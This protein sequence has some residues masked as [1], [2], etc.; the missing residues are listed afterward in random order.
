MTTSPSPGA[1]AR[2]CSM[3]SSTRARCR[4]IR[5]DANAPQ[6]GSLVQRRERA[7]EL[8][9]R[10]VRVRHDPFVRGRALAVHLRDDERHA[11]REPERGRL[12][13]A[14]CAALDGRRHQL[15]CSVP[16]RRRRSRGRA[17][18]RRA[19]RPSLPRPRARRPRRRRS[20]RRSGR[21][22]RA[23][24]AEATLG[25][26]RQRDLPDCAGRADDADAGISHASSSPR[27][28]RARRRHAALR[29]A[30][31][32]SLARDEAADLDRRGASRSPA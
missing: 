24:L 15:A 30:S 18:R 13:H 25:E 16:C 26:K 14:N 4:L 6:A 17:L 11:L 5:R 8:D 7:D 21:G 1:W 27:G 10:A 28:C 20:N 22:E 19:P 2:S 3:R 31:S 23:N 12:V 9:G 29:T 32:T